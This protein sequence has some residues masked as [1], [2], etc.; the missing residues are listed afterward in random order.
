VALNIATRTRIEFLTTANSG[1]GGPKVSVNV[2]QFGGGI[3]NIKFL[4]GEIVTIAGSKDPVENART[5]LVYATFWIEKVTHPHH[6]L[7]F[8]QLQYAQMVV[9]DFPIFHL[10]HPTAPPIA[11]AYVN[12][13]WPHVTVA[14]LR[15]SFG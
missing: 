6:G 3:E 14:T 5:A 2:P 10:L 8:M 4:N 15:K 12:L 7:S 9:L 13:G 11:P 1:A